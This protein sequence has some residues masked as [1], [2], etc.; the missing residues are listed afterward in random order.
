MSAAAVT[1]K[2]VKGL[3][4][5]LTPSEAVHAIRKAIRTKHALFLWGAPGI[6]KSSVAA[7]VADDMGIAF[8]DV[9]LSQMDAPDIRGMAYPA[10]V[11]GVEGLVWSPPLVLPR[12]LDTQVVTTISATETILRFYNHRGDNGIYT[13]RDPQITVKAIDPNHTA[14]VLHI[15]PDFFIAVLRDSAG[16]TVEGQITYTV[17]GKARAIVA[18]EEFNSADETI[19]AASYQLILNRRIGDYIVP[20]GCGLIAMGNRET[21]KA[22]AFQISTA[23]SNR[24]TH[25]LMKHD[26]RDWMRWATNRGDVHPDV[27]SFI[28]NWGDEYLFKFNP[29]SGEKSFP[30]PR[31]WE[32]VSQDMWDEDQHGDTPARVLNAMVAGSVGT[33]AATMF[34]SHRTQAKELPD[35]ETILSGSL[36]KLPKLPDVSLAANLTTRLCSRLSREVKDL[37][38]KYASDRKA[39]KRSPEYTEYV[40]RADRAFAFMLSNFP[41]EMQVAGAKIALGTYDLPLDGD[42]MPNFARFVDKHRDYILQPR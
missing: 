17:K 7:Q 23:L 33:S 41:P 26:Q 29:G 19:Q 28:Q 15:G 13:C 14:E 18:L 25:V 4:I 16:Q 40:A 9:R 8:I 31:T 10:T 27:I 34:L 1:T 39:W 38:G 20:E 5:E 30:T 32:F 42:R 12:D 21:D 36:K 24:F 11:G 3:V 37:K 35:P 6:S 2:E 22:I